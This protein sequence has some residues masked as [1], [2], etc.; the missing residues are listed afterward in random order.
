MNSTPSHWIIFWSFVAIEL[1]M[2]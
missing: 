2:Q 1:N